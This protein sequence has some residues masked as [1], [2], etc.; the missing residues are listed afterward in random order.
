MAIKYQMHSVISEKDGI[1]RLMNM[2]TGAVVNKTWSS[3]LDF[4][5]RTEVV[6]GIK[7]LLCEFT[8]IFDRVIL[9]GSTARNSFSASSDIDIYIESKSLTT[10]RLLR[11][12][13]VGL[14]GDMLFNLLASYNLY[15]VDL[16]YIG[17]NE[18]NK[19][20][21]IMHN[22]EE[23]GIVLYDSNVR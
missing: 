3:S 1:F 7:N 22:I 10:G 18:L 5:E 21:R 23:D 11:H 15:D 13:R 16:L 8:D 4:G 20:R 2:T 17:R 14:F 12:K 6:R 9:F 19:E